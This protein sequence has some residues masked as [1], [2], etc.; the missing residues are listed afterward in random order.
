MSLVVL[1]RKTKTK[2]GRISSGGAFNIGPRTQSYSLYNPIQCCKPIWKP[3]ANQSQSERVHKEKVERAKC[4]I[5]QKTDSDGCKCDEGK[6]RGTKIGSGSYY[7]D[8]NVGSSSDY[9]SVYESSRT[10]FSQEAVPINREC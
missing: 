8:L 4:Y 5:V 7:K 10:C 9:I 2:Q 3:V 1:Q 6:Y